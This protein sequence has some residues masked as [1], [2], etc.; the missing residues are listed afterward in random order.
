M[1]KKSCF[2]F[3]S[4]SSCNLIIFK[5][6]DDI[7]VFFQNCVIFFNRTVPVDFK[8]YQ[9][10][11]SVLMNYGFDTMIAC[12]KVPLDSATLLLSFIFTGKNEQTSKI[13]IQSNR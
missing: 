6:E 9:G 12:H 2:S 1:N 13:F 4:N 8:S 5:S 11:N 3:N 10:N 7:I